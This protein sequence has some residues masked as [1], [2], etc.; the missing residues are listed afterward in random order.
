MQVWPEAQRKGKVTYTVM[1]LCSC[2]KSSL[3]LLRWTKSSAAH[4]LRAGWP[5]S[6]G[7]GS[8]PGLGRLGI[9]RQCWPC[10]SL[11][12]RAPPLPGH[13]H[14]H[15]RGYCTPQ[16]TVPA[17]AGPPRGWL[18]PSG[19]STQSAGPFSG[20]F[21]KQVCSGGCQ[22]PIRGSAPRLP[23]SDLLILLL[24]GPWPADQATGTARESVSAL[25]R[26]RTKATAAPSPAH[27]EESPSP[28]ILKA[29]LRGWEQPPL[30][31]GL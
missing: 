4:L 17:P 28:A 23:G 20:L 13:L 6:S 5:G 19:Q 29:V 26:A 16:S 2:Q 7:S 30:I 22:R 24:P 12:E 31:Y 1:F 8:T 9:Q 25:T 18:R 27:F 11:G 3:P 21:S 10:V 15:H 14:P